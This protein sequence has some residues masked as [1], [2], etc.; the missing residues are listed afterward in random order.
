MTFWEINNQAAQIRRARRG[1]SDVMATTGRPEHWAGC[2]THCRA[3][4]PRQGN[5]LPHSGAG[6]GTG[7][8]QRL[9]TDPVPPHAAPSAL[10]A[11][12]EIN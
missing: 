10:T 9:R 4:L 5:A 7:S 2:Y 1:G 6:R 11:N 3:V 12:E 8:E